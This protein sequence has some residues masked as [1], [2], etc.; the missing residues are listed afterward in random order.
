MKKSD[1]FF[2]AAEDA[3]ARGHWN[4]AVSNAV[5][6]GISAGDALAVY[7]LGLR[8]ATQNHAEHVRLLHGLPFDK[9]E[10]DQNVAHLT[11]LLSVKHASQYEDR[12]LGPA[13]AESALQHARRFRAWVSSKS[14][15]RRP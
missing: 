5:H 1:E 3:A 14:A 10:L 12:L 11:R 15:A 2:A 9:D 8:S 13:D 7:H 6:A 4:A